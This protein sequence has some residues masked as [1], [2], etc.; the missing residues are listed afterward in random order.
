MSTLSFLVGHKY[1]LV[2]EV[3]GALGVKFSGSSDIWSDKSPAEAQSSQRFTK[4]LIIE[5]ARSWNTPGKARK[6]PAD[7]L[8]FPLPHYFSLRLRCE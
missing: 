6:E 8:S 4:R 1:K 3:G 5:L 7:A 2:R